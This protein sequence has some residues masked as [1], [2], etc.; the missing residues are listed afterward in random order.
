MNYFSV[1]DYPLT[2]TENGVFQ[3]PPNLESPPLSPSSTASG[4]YIPIS[5]CTSGT[6]FH[7]Y[8]N[9]NECY[10]CPR[11]LNLPS[12]LD[13]RGSGSNSPP[14]Q[15]PLT[16][17]ESVFTDE[18]CVSLSCK[19]VVNWETFPNPLEGSLED[20]KPILC[21]SRHY[22]KPLPPPRPPKPQNLSVLESRRSHTYCN[23]EEINKKGHSK[24]AENL[25]E[26]YDFPRSHALNGQTHF[27]MNICP[28]SVGSLHEVDSECYNEVVFRYD[29]PS[30]SSGD[31]SSI[32][33]GLQNTKNAPIVDR[34]LKPGRKGSD[35]ASNEP[36][37]VLCGFPPSIDRSL[38]P[39]SISNEV[40][41]TISSF[42]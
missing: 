16:D 21:G 28:K 32:N 14:L 26:M 27:S 29:F 4:P 5:E 24:S 1:C 18:E 39:F 42:I 22:R 7:S 6:P 23:I 31:V 20:M 36:S 25:D 30:L 15:S 35:S 12:N 34:G 41:G 38:K 3:D 8:H 10:D 40:E 9:L 37:P 33:S 2:E 17:G 11:K 19:P 13:L